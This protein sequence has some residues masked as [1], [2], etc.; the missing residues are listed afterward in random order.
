[1]PIPDPPAGAHLTYSQQF[2]RCGKADCPACGTGRPG[3]GPY[4]YAYWRDGGRVRSRYL[5]RT[6]PQ[7]AEPSLVSPV[8]PVQDAEVHDTATRATAPQADVLRIQT[9]GAFQVWCGGIPIPHD[10]WGRRKAGSLVKCLLAVAEQ[11]LHREQ[12]AELLW[13]EAFPAVG[14]A[15]LRAAIH[16]VRRILD[17]RSASSHLQ[18]LEGWLTLVPAPTGTADP[19]WLDAAAFTRTAT[20][21]LE[22][23]SRTACHVALTRYTGEYLPDDVY[24]EWAVGRREE[25]RQIRLAVLLHLA[26]LC[27]A[28]GLVDVAERSLQQVLEAD[29]CHERATQSL[30]R[31]LAADGRGAEAI[32]IYQ[33]LDRT[34]KRELGLVPEP[35]TQALY[36]ALR[37]GSR[38]V[39]AAQDVINDTATAPCRYPTN[40][41]APLTSFVGREQVIAEISALLLQGGPNRRLVSL[42]G[43]GGCG[44]TRLALE[45][46]GT[47]RPDYPDGVWLVELAST[48][49]DPSTDP[50]PVV[51]V[52]ANVLGLREEPHRPLR[53]ALADF[54]RPRRLLLVLDNCEHLLAACGH[55][56]LS[57]L[58]DCTD[59]QILATAREALDVPGEVWWRVPPLRFPVPAQIGA[60]VA[61]GSAATPRAST[62]DLLRFE[63]VQLFMERA[64]NRRPGFA[65]TVAGT[66]T[67]AQICCRLEGIPLAIEL[68]A[69]R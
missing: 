32:R 17:A 2:R 67:I 40:L 28:D 57:L 45:V 35:K 55:L 48:P 9:L 26:H 10:A 8:S 5:G 30:M 19:E 61:G 59:V 23:R 64:R 7:G 52:I 39:A 68:A 63:A 21:A 38:Y 62:T 46:A 44:K 50:A 42:I 69:A 66:R 1:M 15:N 49:A 22:A 13:P 36:R 29:P 54:L 53:A 47:L 34:L 3:H 16:Q 4:W 14:A 33:R 11:R 37:Q 25:L 27:V 18:V 58:Q 31:L 43:T 20:A 56:T 41:P 6:L 60:E 24:A 51:R 65:P 12:A